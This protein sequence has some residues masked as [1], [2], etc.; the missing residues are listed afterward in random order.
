MTH[1]STVFCVSRTNI[2][3]EQLSLVVLKIY[4]DKIMF[5]FSEMF[6]FSSVKSLFVSTVGGMIV[7]FG[8][9]KAGFPLPQR[10]C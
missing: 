6:I 3:P 8:T 7:F 9:Q 5:S 1:D 2:F 4:V 10:G